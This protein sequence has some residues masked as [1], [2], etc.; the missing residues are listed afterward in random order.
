M[1]CLGRV[2]LDGRNEAT[3]NSFELRFD[4]LCIGVGG[5]GM[6]VISF[7]AVAGISRVR[8]EGALVQEGHARSSCES[9]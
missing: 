4:C 3:C 7:S 6:V 9:L 2:V 5:P 1:G 8:V